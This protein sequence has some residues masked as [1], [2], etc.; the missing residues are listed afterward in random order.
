V[1]P[2]EKD[3]YAELGKLAVEFAIM[4]ERL[5]FIFVGMFL[6]TKKRKQIIRVYAKKNGMSEDH[7]ANIDL[8]LM[9][10]DCDALIF[11]NNQS[12]KNNLEKNLQ[13]LRELCA[14]NEKSTKKFLPLIDRIN[15]VKIKRNAFI[16]GIWHV[17]ADKGKASVNR[18][19]THDNKKKTQYERYFGE[20]STSYTLEE[21]RSISNEIVAI[22]S[23]QEKITNFL[24]Q[25]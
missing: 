10:F 1:T 15:K 11:M 16:H 13:Q 7:V 6:R 5:S 25:S 24:Y 20:H 3:F 22:N 12:K 17:D 8:L 14:L 18:I 23:I 21:I 19:I 2:F 4:E 9:R